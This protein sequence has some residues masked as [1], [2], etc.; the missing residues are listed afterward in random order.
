MNTA[1]KQLQTAPPA[2][3]NVLAAGDTTFPS[4]LLSVPASAPGNCAGID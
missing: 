4:A 1:I 2:V 3:G